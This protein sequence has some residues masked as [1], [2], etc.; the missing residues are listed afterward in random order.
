MKL[1]GVE[2]LGAYNTPGHK[3][4]HRIKYAAVPISLKMLIE[5]GPVDAPI[6]GSKVVVYA[7]DYL[8]C[9]LEVNWMLILSDDNI[10]SDEEEDLDLEL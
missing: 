5:N 10:D 4:V 9:P 8:P 7:D 3:Y 2:A 6:S 1:V